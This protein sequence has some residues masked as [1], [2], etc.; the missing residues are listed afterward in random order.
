MR[1]VQLVVMKALLLHFH[2]D[3]DMRARSLKLVVISSI[4]LYTYKFWWP[5]VS[6]RGI[7]RPKL[8]LVFLSDI[9]TDQVHFVNN[10]YSLCQRFQPPPLTLLEYNGWNSCLFNAWTPYT[11]LRVRHCLSRVFPTLYGKCISVEF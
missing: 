7:W 10:N 5:Y 11:F 6:H 4:E 1:A 3:Y 2:G 9:W 8:Q